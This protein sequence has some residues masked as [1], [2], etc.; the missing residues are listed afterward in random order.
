MAEWGGGD[1]WPGA[2][3]VCLGL[4]LAS[5]S[6]FEFR[7]VCEPIKVEMC[8]SVDYN[9]TGMPNLAGSAR[10]SDAQANLETFLPLVLS[11]CS[12]ELVFFLCSIYTPVCVSEGDLVGPCRPLCQRVR[13]SCIAQ[14]ERV[15]M[16][17][18][19]MLQCERFPE[20]NDHDHMCMERPESHRPAPG[21]SVS[22]SA[23]N[24][25]RN[26]EIFMKK[27]E[28]YYQNGPMTGPDSQSQAL[29]NVFKHSRG[30]T[31]GMESDPYGGPCQH[32]RQPKKW[33]Y[34]EH[35]SRCIPECEADIQ[36]SPESKAMA[37]Q[38]MVGLTVVSSLVALF[39]LISFLLDA[40]RYQYPERSII[41]ITFSALGYNF[42]YASRLVFGREATSCLPSDTPAS[43]L[44]LTVEGHRNSHCFTVFLFL[45]FFSC[46]ITSWWLVTTLTWFLTT[47]LRMPAKQLYRYVT[48]YHIYAWGVAAF[49]TILLAVT[50]QIHGDEFTGT[51]GPAVQDDEGLFRY[52]ILPESIQ[53][54]L[55][56]LFLLIGLVM[57][58]SQLD[59]DDGARFKGIISKMLP[60]TA[61]F[62]LAKLLILASYI[63]EFQRRS[64]WLLKE[65]DVSAEADIFLLRLCMSLLFGVL[66]GTWI[67]LQGTVHTWRREITY[68]CCWSKD[69][70]LPFP[71]VSYS[72]QA[73]SINTEQE[74]SY[75]TL[76]PGSSPG[77]Q[78]HY[79]QTQFGNST[80]T[81]VLTN[82][83]S[84]NNQ[85][86][87]I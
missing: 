37:Q 74:A 60:Y 50:G 81:T 33:H 66:S 46:A 15:N 2:W 55:G 53:L 85:Q 26:N 30:H 57:A 59:S 87:F 11:R 52:V 82:N 56:L 21:L 27:V 31:S 69:K 68:R 40:D 7:P 84:T 86:I 23:Y 44:L 70:S 63:Y 8:L 83:H 65:I 73:Q 19:S 61:L 41:F 76:R 43:T 17:W 78:R 3:L 51:C 10:Q 62:F 24:N 64:Q 45:N 5:A 35:L 48:F 71:A 36:F 1:R 22:S 77:Q 29:L 72:K 9:M 38:C 34:V 6:R 28:K 18:P 25:L 12:N 54:G 75:A 49:L 39:T 20:T 47:T 79:K 67:M 42:G 14:F 4:S 58:L 16:A 13:A 32:L 80:V